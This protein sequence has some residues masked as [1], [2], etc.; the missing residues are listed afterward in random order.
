MTLPFVNLSEACRV[1]GSTHLVAAVQAVSA[2]I[3]RF[4]SLTQNDSIS[5]VKFHNTNLPEKTLLFS[6]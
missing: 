4:A 6:S 1:E 2:K 3:L 5:T